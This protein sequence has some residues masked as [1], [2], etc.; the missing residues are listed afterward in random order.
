MVEGMD[1]LN[2]RFR[3]L[4]NR[5]GR[6]IHD[7][8]DKGAGEVAATAKT[9]APVD[10][11]ELR[12]SIEHTIAPM[13]MDKGAVAIVKTDLF[14]SRFVEF[15]SQG[16]PAQPFFFPAYFLLRKRVTRR[17]RRAIKKAAKINNGG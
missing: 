8:L 13:A 4:P 2:R 1:R 6:L 14:Y 17:I 7:A 5:T 16:R 10:S 15:G 3:D 9:L 12:D 11:G